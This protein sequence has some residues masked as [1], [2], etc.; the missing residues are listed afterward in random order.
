MEKANINIREHER[1]G[2]TFTIISQV[3]YFNGLRFQLPFSYDRYEKIE[4]LTS[5][6][7]RNLEENSLIF[8]TIN[9]ICN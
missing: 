5:V 8:I 4:K 6:T 2:I 1:R 7:I 9:A 3:K